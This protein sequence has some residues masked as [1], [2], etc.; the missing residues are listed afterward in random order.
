MNNID[1]ALI[2]KEGKKYLGKKIEVAG[3]LRTVRDSKN[4][5]FLAVNDGTCLLLTRTNVKKGYQV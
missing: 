1:I 4:M 5:M 3:W 2:Q